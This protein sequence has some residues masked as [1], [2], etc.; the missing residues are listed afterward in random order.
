MIIAQIVYI[1][2]DK[3]WRNIMNGLYIMILP[4]YVTT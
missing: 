1:A 2:I 3:L 4:L